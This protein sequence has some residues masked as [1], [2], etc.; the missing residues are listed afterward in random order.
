MAQEGR[1]RHDR[2]EEGRHR[3]RQGA[4]GGRRRRH[5]RGDAA[6]DVRRLRR[7]RRREAADATEAREEGKGDVLL[8]GPGS[9]LQEGA[10]KKGRR[11]HGGSPEGRLLEDGGV[12]GV[13]LQRDGRR[14]RRR[15]RA[16]AVEGPR[17]VPTYLDGHGLRGNAHE[18]LG[19]VVLLEL[20]RPLPAPVAP[21]PRRPR[22][23]L[24]QEPEGRPDVAGRLLRQGQGHARTRGRHR[25]PGSPLRLRRRRGEEKSTA[26]AYHGR[27][28][29]RPSS[30]RREHPRRKTLHP[31]QVLLDRPR[32][33]QRNH[34]LHPPLRIPPGRGPRRGLRPLPRKSHLHHTH[35]LRQH[36]HHPAPLQARLQPLHRALHG[37]L[38]IPPRPQEVDRN[39]YV[40]FFVASRLA[41]LAPSRRCCLVL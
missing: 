28:G 12:Q 39:R 27:L 36:R 37:G 19:R 18:P 17:G 16:T 20:R 26:D 22:H 13:Q 5:G 6:A 29:A 3:R 40:V 10:K 32:L 31:R 8:R 4:P 14:R 7:R 21:R 15:L 1:R 24:R 34:G 25:L 2:R 41:R 33:P 30:A 9:S 23:V 35:L 38:R 11:P